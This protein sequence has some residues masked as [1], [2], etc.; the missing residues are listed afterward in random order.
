MLT[1][2]WIVTWEERIGRMT[3][4]RFR[5]LESMQDAMEFAAGIPAIKQ[6][7]VKAEIKEVA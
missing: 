5:V 4:T 1:Q 2:K 6:P 3:I 7:H